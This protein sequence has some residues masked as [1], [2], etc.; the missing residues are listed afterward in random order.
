MQ[1]TDER[2]WRLAELWLQTNPVLSRADVAERMGVSLF[3][4]A[5]QGR[6]L[7]LPHKASGVPNRRPRLQ[8]VKKEIPVLS[9]KIVVAP[10]REWAVVR[11]GL[12]P[13]WTAKDLSYWAAICAGTVLECGEP[14]EVV[15]EP[16]CHRHRALAAG[17]GV[18][19]A[20]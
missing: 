20:A 5:Q 8:R 15:G 1:W 7:E 19:R 16:Y 4:V 13:T 17:A 14:T 9:E 18:L 6:R 10:V 2:N 12:W 11:G 3:A